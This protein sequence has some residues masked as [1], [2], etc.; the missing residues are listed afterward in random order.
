M[1]CKLSR[2]E[3]RITI[4][5]SPEPRIP[6]ELLRKTNDKSACNEING[7]SWLHYA[8]WYGLIFDAKEL[9]NLGFEVS[10]IDCVTSIQITEKLRYIL[11]A[12]KVT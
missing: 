8:A 1:G 2:K 9:I 12:I 10:S 4:T 3:S 6:L 7:W 5:V 11:H